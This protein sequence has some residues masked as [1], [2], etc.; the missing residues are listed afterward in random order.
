MLRSAT[1][2]SLRALTSAANA[3]KSSNVLPRS[4]ASEAAADY[5]S[6]PCFGLN[7][8]QQSFLELTRDFTANE[9]IP[10]AAE[11]D[12]SMAYPWEV[13]KKAHAAGLMNSAFL[14]FVTV[15]SYCRGR[16]LR[17]E[18]TVN[19]ATTRGGQSRFIPPRATTDLPGCCVLLQL[20]SLKS[21]VD[22]DW[23]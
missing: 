3:A 2:K 20:I 1:S 8:D 17:V 12:R 21:L 18:S 15:L 5:S 11:F 14:C 22:P 16:G 10:V 7:E 23:A 4:Y 13:I 19:P 9:I 6:G